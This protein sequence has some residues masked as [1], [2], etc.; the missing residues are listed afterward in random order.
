MGQEIT[1][2]QNEIK[3]VGNEWKA[4]LRSPRHD[5]LNS[6]GECGQGMGLGW[7]SLSLLSEGGGCTWF[8]PALT[9]CPFPPE[10]CLNQQWRGVS[11]WSGT[12]FA[13]LTA[14][15]PLKPPVSEPHTSPPW[16]G[17]NEYR[18]WGL[19]GFCQCVNQ[20]FP[21]ILEC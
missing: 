21:K 20:K 7:C 14:A 16:W 17:D 11:W 10:R 2:N 19:L 6:G 5:Q 4:E 13:S 15:G 8:C 3:G 1:K 12:V 18:D 9:S